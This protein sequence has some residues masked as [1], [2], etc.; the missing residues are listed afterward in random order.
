MTS[1]TGRRRAR[2][3]HVVRLRRFS[4]GAV[5]DPVAVAVLQAAA[6]RDYP[7]N[8]VDAIA[9]IGR[10]DDTGVPMVQVRWLG[11]GRAFD[12]W[13]PAANIAEDVP[14]KLLSFLQARAD[15]PICVEL[16]TRYFPGVGA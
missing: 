12:T 14:S 5:G 8:V 1:V 15:V 2:A 10:D 4:A 6:D 16:L 11:F 9:D 13:E 7:N 3:V